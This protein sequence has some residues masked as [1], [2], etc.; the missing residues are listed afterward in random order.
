VAN[1][2]GITLPLR[3]GQNGYFESTS[4]VMA[5]VKTNLTNL[6]LTQKGERMMQ[7]DF[8]C[9]L[10][11]SMFKTSTDNGLADVQAAIDA[12]VKEWMPFVSVDEVKL[13]NA[14]GDHNYMVSIKYT[15]LTT[16]TTDSITLVF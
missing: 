6:L 5:Q 4:D 1:R 15:L 11:L 16:N 3:L 12:A 14:S 9:D 8:G 7:P 13:V 10:P 2:L